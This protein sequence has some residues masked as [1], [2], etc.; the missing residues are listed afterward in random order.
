MPDMSGRQLADAALAMRPGLKVLYATGYTRNAIVHNGVVDQNV[1][2]LA[3]PFS[4]D[5]LARKM[6]SVLDAD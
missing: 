6:R 4:I 2:F 1:V 5:A 3:A